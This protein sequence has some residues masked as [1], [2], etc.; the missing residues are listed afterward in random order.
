MDSLDKIP[1]EIEENVL[2]PFGV[3]NLYPNIPPLLG[4]E[5]IT[6][7]LDNYWASIMRPSLLEFVL[8]AMSLVLKEN[9]FQFDGR[10]H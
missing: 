9:T 6:Y 3:I 1:K 7:Q 5:A 2:V 4:L 10:N 8:K